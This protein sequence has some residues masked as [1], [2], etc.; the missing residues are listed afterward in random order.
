M[1]RIWKWIRIEIQQ[2]VAF[3]VHLVYSAIS[4]PGNVVN[5]SH[6]HQVIS[7]PHTGH[8]VIVMDHKS[9]FVNQQFYFQSCPTGLPNPTSLSLEKNIPFKPVLMLI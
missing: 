3:L 9:W 5:G 8:N 1:K 7:R 6:H 2:N 4:L